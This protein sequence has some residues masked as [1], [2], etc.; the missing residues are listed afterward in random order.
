MNGARAGASGGSRYSLLAGYALSA[1]LAF[2]ILTL[3]VR[4]RW[5]L[6][7]FQLAVLA[8]TLAWSWAYA[9]LGGT[10]RLRP[11]LMPLAFIPAWGCLQLMLGKTLHPWLTSEEALAWTVCLCAAFLMLQACGHPRFRRWFPAALLIF[12][13]LL[14]VQ[15][16]LQLFTSP[17][18]VFWLFDSG[19]VAMVLGPFVYHN[20]YA[21]FVELIL[22]LALWRAFTHRRQAPLWLVAAAILFAGV[23]AGASRSGFALLLLETLLVILLAWRRGLLSGRASALILLQ[24]TALLAAWGF[25]AG[26]DYLLDR[27]AGLD[28]L[29]DLRFPMMRST[30]TMAGRFPLWGCGLGAWPAVYPEFAVFDIGLIANQA[31][32]DWLQWAAEGGIPVLGAF[33]CLAALLVR[34]L[35]RSGWGSGFLVVMVHAALDYP[36]HQ[37]PAFTALLFCAALAAAESVESVTSS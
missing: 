36:F 31:H 7:A 26:W 33:L 2:G 16:L 35:L 28:P 30:L 27:L 32:C 12:G 1:V 8:L 18:K 15:A 21:Q 13:S 3:W 5:A 29:S 4:Q 6:A 37:L 25:I 17:G 14:G 24:A 34:P 19:Y 22:P 9:W 10:V 20:K 23:V 11:W